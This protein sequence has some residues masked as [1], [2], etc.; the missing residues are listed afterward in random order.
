VIDIN[1]VSNVA[2]KCT[3]CYDRLQVGMEPA[4]SQACPTDSIRFGPI[5]EMRELAASRV[6][7]LHQLGEKRAYLYGADDKFLGG[8]NSF[9]LL[10]DEPEVYGLPRAPK[11]PTRNLIPA[12]LLS[13]GGAVVLALLG[14]VGLRK[15]RMDEKID[16]GTSEARDV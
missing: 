9:Y 14:M 5:R 12:S 6:E 16:Q 4:C 3:L 8:L 13:A 11:M 1:D 10:V 2:Q 7:Q 15:R